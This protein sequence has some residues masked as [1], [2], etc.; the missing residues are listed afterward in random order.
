MLMRPA[1]LYV[2]PRSAELADLGL[3]SPPI[4]GNDD[5]AIGST[6][7]SNDVLLVSYD[8]FHDKPHPSLPKD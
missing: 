1:D 2:I 5:G 6:V 8:G 4:D 7:D 3:L